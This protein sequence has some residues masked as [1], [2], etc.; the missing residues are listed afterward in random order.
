ML[1]PI[2][3]QLSWE[4]ES[5]PHTL[6]LNGLVNAQARGIWGKWIWVIKGQAAS[7][8]SSVKVSSQNPGATLGEV[9]ATCRCS[10]WQSQLNASPKSSW[11]RRQI[12]E[13][14]N[15]NARDPTAHLFQPS[16]IQVTH[17]HLS[18]PC[19]DP[20]HC[21]VQPSHSCYVPYKFLTF[22]TWGHNKTVVLH[23]S[24]W[25]VYAT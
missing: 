14:E 7:G 3:W 17:R 18:L 5:T 25:F 20:K 10:Y 2:F 11:S 8:L 12:C 4:V 19:W 24:K 21:G 13:W 16:A 6:D 9:Q 22:R 1:P 23:V 15:H